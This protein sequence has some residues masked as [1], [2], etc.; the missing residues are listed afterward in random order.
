MGNYF[1]LRRLCAL[2][3]VFIVLLTISLSAPAQTQILTNAVTLELSFGDETVGNEFLLARPYAI[4]VTGSGDILVA[5][6]YKI[7]VFDPGGKEKAIMGGRGEGPG[8]FGYAFKITIGP[9]GLVA[10]SNIREINLF[11]SDYGLL[12][13]T[14]TRNS[15]VHYSILGV[16]KLDFFGWR[17]V[18]AL[19]S[20]ESIIVGKA[21]KYSETEGEPW[22]SFDLIMHRNGNRAVTIIGYEANNIVQGF[23]KILGVMSRISHAYLGEFHYS[24]GSFGRVVYTHTGHDTKN[25]NGENVYI[26]RSFEYDSMEKSEVEITYDPV[27]IPERIIKD[28][29]LVPAK[30]VRSGGGSSVARRPYDDDM[31]DKLRRA[32]FLPPI[33]DLVADGNYAFAFVHIADNGEREVADVIDLTT[34]KVVSRTLFPVR[35]NVIRNGYA[36]VLKTGQDIFPVVEKYRIDP[37]VYHK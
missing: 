34:G 13:K 14:S 8:E 16:T 33:Y 7:K 36:Y 15:L 22:R 24:L 11:G 27:P 12:T 23:N 1:I 5:D 3:G 29:I 9:S 26:I 31:R 30:G 2:N 21:R 18:I 20:I 19:N 32:K 28:A 10:A 37:A 25:D 6:E 35:P 17:D 4:A